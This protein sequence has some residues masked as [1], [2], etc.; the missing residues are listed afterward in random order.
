MVFS[1]LKSKKKQVLTPEDTI[2][3]AIGDIHGRDDL[4]AELISIIN[5][6]LI[7]NR[8]GKKT[9]MVFLGDYV[10]RGLG[11][12]MVIDILLILANE[13]NR[14]G[15]WHNTIF[16]KGNH[17][18]ALLH[19]LDEPDFGKKWL[20]HGGTETLISYGVGVPTDK[21]DLKGWQETANA[22]ET[23]LGPTHL[24]FFNNLK[25]YAEIG[26]YAFVHAGLR[27]GKA[28]EQQSAQDLL[29][30]RGD[31]LDSAARFDKK[32]VHGHTPKKKTFMDHRRIGIDTGAYITGVLTAVRLEDD[33][34]SFLQ[35]GADQPG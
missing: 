23:A 34:V 31:F 21:K 9:M 8:R 33:A 24:S 12:K 35:T 19:F 11:S 3:Y 2:I 14:A 26:D 25:P 10:D 16:L 7:E 1:W 32:I 22:L 5:Q 18:E 6:D 4:L 17:E 30:I 13:A 27:P 28:I 20:A 29:W 15:A